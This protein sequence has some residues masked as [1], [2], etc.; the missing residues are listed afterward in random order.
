MIRVRDI[1]L[2]P[3]EDGDE[4]LREAI[5]K[6]LG[7]GARR[8]GR[9]KIVR[10]SIDARRKN[11]VRLIYT[12]DVSVP[13]EA[14]LLKRGGKISP[15]P[16][17][18][19]EPPA[20][21]QPG[22]YRPVV[23]GFGPAGMFAA[24]VLAGAGLCPLV[25][26][27]GSDVK[28][29]REKV[30]RFWSG[31]ELDGECNVQFGEGGA[32]TFSDGKLNTGTGDKRIGWVLRKFADF[33]APESV[34]YDAAPHV[35]TDILADVV[36]NLRRKIIELGGEVRFNTRL[37]GLITDNGR[38]SGVE[39]ESGGRRESIKTDSVI[40]AVGHSA[41]DTFEM[42][43][44]MGIPMEPKAFS[45]GVRVEHL[46]KQIDRS[47]FGAFAGHKALGAAPYKLNCRT[48]SGSAY[49][50]CMCPGGY[51]VAAASEK[52][53]IVTNGMSYS[54]RGGENANSALLV[55]LTPDMFPHAGVMGGVTWQREIERAA[56]AAAGGTYMAPAQLMGDFLEGRPSVGA[57]VVKPTYRPGVTW[58]GLDTVLPP[59]ITAPLR[60][61]MPVL[62]RKLHGF[63]D[64]DA[65]LT[66]PETRSSSPVRV[67]R[68]SDMCSALPG[69]YPCGEGAGY[70]GGIVSAAV[71][72]IRCAEAVISASEK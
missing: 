44:K 14:A 60:E 27:R 70:A 35:G 51:V 59:I 23:V 2:R 8:L 65:V 30:E 21:A 17:D 66:A 12:A 55:T 6:I 16:D 39:W 42:L 37:T 49:T 62:D 11:D 13:N 45:M 54:G 48:E 33:G 64:P 9:V 63:L 29:R 26:E 56:F 68:G 19:Y 46:Q 58:C 1:S 41:R 3:Q 24:L 61:A 69:L 50:F 7:I 15:V 38:I 25:I 52:G 5:A 72:G 36:L 4:G 67:L 10:R 43:L 71:D 40:L 57:G 20:A 32:G 34:T 47:Q 22:R 18:H 31:S 28:T 53:G